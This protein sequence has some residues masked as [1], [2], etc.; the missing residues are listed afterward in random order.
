[1]LNKVIATMFC[2]FFFIGCA[3][4]ANIISNPV[5]ALVRINGETVGNTPAVAK[6]H[7]STFE[8]PTIELSKDGYRTLSTKLEFKTDIGAILLDA[9]F[10]W[11]ALFFNAACP[12][13]EYHFDL[14]AL[15][16]SVLEQPTLTILSGSL[17]YRIYIDEELLP[18]GER[19]ILSPGAH[20]VSV[21][22]DNQIRTSGTIDLKANTDYVVS[23]SL[24]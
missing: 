13:D 8:R 18:Y 5:G 14:D 15:K 19:R 2:L 3:H 20:H 21:I 23:P 4:K 22:R 6:I 16:V 17:D 12:K 1:M 7:C 9:A 24:L 10:L 11:P